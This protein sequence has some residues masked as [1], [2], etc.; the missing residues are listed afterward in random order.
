MEEVDMN[1]PPRIYRTRPSFSQFKDS[2]L[3]LPAK[4]LMEI[5]TS[6]PSPSTSPRPKHAYAYMPQQQQLQIPGLGGFGTAGPLFRDATPG[7]DRPMSTTYSTPASPV[8]TSSPTMRSQD[9]QEEDGEAE[10]EEEGE[11]GPS[12]TQ[13]ARTILLLASSPTRPPPRTLNVGSRHASPSPSPT[14]QQQAMFGEPLFLNLK[15]PSS[16]TTGASPVTGPAS[17]GAGVGAGAGAGIGLMASYSPMTSSPLVKFQT[18]ASTP[19]PDRSPS[20]ATVVVATDENDHTDDGNPFLVKKGIKESSLGSN[21]LTRPSSGLH[22]PMEPSS[23]S[24][25]P[26]QSAPGF[27]S[28]INTAADR[29]TEVL[30]EN[31][32]NTTWEAA[33]VV[34]EKPPLVATGALPHTPQGPQQGLEGSSAAPLGIR[35]PPPSGNQDL[36]QGGLYGHRHSPSNTVAQSIAARRRNSGLAGGTGVDLLT[37]FPRPGQSP[38]EHDNGTE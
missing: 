23:L 22:E 17:S 6:S 35:T 11:G 27:R 8:M 20:G 21:R 30:R 2:E 29:T 1:P 38:L 24:A 28:D 15:S 14:V 13:A 33:S 4:S 3:F 5:A 37:F 16:A 18:A 36:A 32:E 19:S 26:Q 9:K 12:D 34:K 25:P 7:R 10:E 31:P